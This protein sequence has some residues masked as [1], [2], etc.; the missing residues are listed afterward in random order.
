MYCRSPP[1]QSQV[2]ISF[3]HSGH[4]LM[5]LSFR[6]FVRG[7]PPASILLFADLEGVAVGKEKN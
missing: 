2:S 1:Q 7:R 3:P 5:M 4:W 6:G